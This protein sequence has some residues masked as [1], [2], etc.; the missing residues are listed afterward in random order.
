MPVPSQGHYGF[1]SFP[2][3]NNKTFLVDLAK[4]KTEGVLKETG[5][6]YP[7][8]ASRYTPVVCGVRVVSSVGCIVGLSRYACKISFVDCVVGLSRYV[9]KTWLCCWIV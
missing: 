4:R 9:S 8:R 7:F 1:H 3:V 5:T 2:V 6:A